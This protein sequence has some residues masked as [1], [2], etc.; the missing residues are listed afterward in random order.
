MSPSSALLVIAIGILFFMQTTQGGLVDRLKSYLPDED[1]PKE[2]GRPASAFVPRNV[3]RRALK[4]AAGVRRGDPIV[5]ERIRPAAM[6]AGG[7]FVVTSWYRGADELTASGTPSC[8]RFGRKSG[9][10]AVDIVHE[11]GKWGPVDRL[12]AE[13][14]QTPGIGEVL[15]RGYA[16]H[17]PALGDNG[18]LHAA[19]NCG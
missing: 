15:F 8:H 2:Q 10:G 9:R 5:L 19:V 11:S 18:H 12:E 13:L 3:G 4:V 6:A 1:G 14:R 17:D 16:G 7:G